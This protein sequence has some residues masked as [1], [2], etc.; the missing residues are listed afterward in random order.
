MEA[1]VLYILQLADK[2]PVVHYIVIGV[3]LAY[4]I[5]T[6]LRAFLTIIVN[7]TKTDKDNKIVKNVFAFL[8][9]YAWG[10]GKFAEY[11]EQHPIKKEKDK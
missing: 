7:L 6:A 5:L 9:K 11:Y 8:D 2:F 4:I 3:G 10:F 1:L